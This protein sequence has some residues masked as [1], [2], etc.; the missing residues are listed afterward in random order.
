MS[1]DSRPF[2]VVA[3]TGRDDPSTM[4]AVRRVIERPGIRLAGVVSDRAPLAPDAR[5]ARPSSPIRRLIFPDD[6]RSLSELCAREGVPYVAVDS[7]NSREAVRH[8]AALDADLGIVVGNRPLH[9]E[10]FAAPRL[11]SIAVQEARTRDYHWARAAFWALH[12]AEPSA[13]VAVH[14]VAEPFDT[15]TLMLEET[16]SIASRESV[17]SLA[18]KLGDLG[19][20]LLADGAELIARGRI[21][22]RP[23][24][25]SPGRAY[26]VPTRAQRAALDRRLGTPREPLPKRALKAAFY[27]VGLDLGPIAAR[28]AWL[29]RRR[30][31]RYTVLL[32]HRVNDVAQDN[33]TT[34]V[35]R[36]IEHLGTLK[37]R[38]PVVSLSAMLEASRTGHYLGPNVVAITFDDGYADNCEIAAPIL[39]HFGLPATFFVSAGLVDTATPFPHDGKS[40][41][42]FRNLTWRQVSDMAARGFEIGSHGWAHRNLAHCSLDEARSEIV[43]SREAIEHKLGIA[44]RSFAYPYGGRHDVTPEVVEEIRTA[45]FQVIAS[46]YGGTNLGRLDSD[47]VLRVGVSEAFDSLALR[48]SVEG[49]TLQAIRRSL[50]RWRGGRRKTGAG[51]RVALEVR[52]H[53]DGRGPR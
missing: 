43:R 4:L 13:G 2:R 20:R 9:R 14:R 21:P 40:P 24:L 6:V 28:N 19:A 10:T 50:G 7:L 25:S 3:L 27:R 31:S 1:T 17:Q 18:V 37:G 44:P 46:A 15:G 41:H 36:F 26:P 30:R 29:R 47:N 23:R 32:Y 39:E 48:A 34:S 35:D 45:G 8:I 22:A 52:T 16:V 42:R 51:R 33:L 49:V 38:Y 11:G 12:D 5:A 53:R